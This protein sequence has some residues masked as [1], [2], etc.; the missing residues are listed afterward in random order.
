MKPDMNNLAR[1][2]GRNLRVEKSYVQG[3]QTGRK[4]SK[5][6]KNTELKVLNTHCTSEGRDHDNAAAVSGS[7]PSLRNQIR[8]LKSTLRVT[9]SL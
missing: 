4:G 2:R 7:R 8:E 9:G 3:E 5:I 6:V 1:K